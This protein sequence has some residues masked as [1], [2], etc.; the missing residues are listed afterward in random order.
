MLYIQSIC[1]QV[2]EPNPLQREEN[3][4]EGQ[5]RWVGTTG[6]GLWPRELLAMGLSGN[7][8]KEERRSLCKIKYFYSFV[9]IK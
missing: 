5:M 4:V 7:L 8:E 6:V 3:L 9:F 2:G 1:R